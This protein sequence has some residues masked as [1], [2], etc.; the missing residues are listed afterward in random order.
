MVEEAGQDPRRL[1]EVQALRLGG[2]STTTRS[3]RWSPWSS[4][5]ASDAMYSWVPL[6][7]WA[8]LR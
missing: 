2:V 1:E 3:K 7:A 4:Y 5:N 8:M 6:S